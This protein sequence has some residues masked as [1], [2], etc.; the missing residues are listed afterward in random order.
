M[1]LEVNMIPAASAATANINGT[2]EDLLNHGSRK[3]KVAVQVVATGLNSADSVMKL[4]ESNDGTNWADIS[5]ATATLASGAS[6][7]LIK[8]TALVCRYIRAVYTKNTNSAG[9]VSAIAFFQ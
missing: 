1:S 2:A 3:E 6:A 9:T 5:G 4:Q 7:P 8:A